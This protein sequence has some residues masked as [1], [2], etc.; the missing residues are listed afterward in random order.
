[1]IADGNIQTATQLGGE[2]H[3]SRIRPILDGIKPGLAERDREVAE[4]ESTMR[5][6]EEAVA[7]RAHQLIQDPEADTPP[8]D[9][10]GRSQSKR[11]AR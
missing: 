8:M 9:V 10:E 4:R 3:I 6:A 11:R 1:M 2:C 5:E 7:C